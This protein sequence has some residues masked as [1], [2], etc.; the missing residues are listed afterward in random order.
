MAYATRQFNSSG[1][2]ASTNAELRQELQERALAEDVLRHLSQRVVQ[3]Q[4]EERRRIAR[5]LHDTIGQYLGAITIGVTSLRDK[6]RPDLRAEVDD[7][8]TNVEKCTRD[9]RTI[10]HLLHPPLLDELG[11]PRRLSGT[12]PSS[13]GG[14]E[15]RRIAR[16]RQNSDG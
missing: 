15:S 13:Q 8:L 14:V 9:V 10:S 16:C 11:C 7:I 12:Y 6:V 1:E 3:L 5:E 2:S 4:D